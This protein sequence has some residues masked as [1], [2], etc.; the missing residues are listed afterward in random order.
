MDQCYNLK[1]ILLLIQ[2]QVLEEL[3]WALILSY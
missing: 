3:G 1:N 2:V